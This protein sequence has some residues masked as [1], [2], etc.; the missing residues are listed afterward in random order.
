MVTTT[1]GAA[2]LILDLLSLEDSRRLLANAV[3]WAL[4]PSAP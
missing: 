4:E 1:A 2:R 3:K